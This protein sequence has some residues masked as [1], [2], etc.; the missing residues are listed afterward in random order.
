MNSTKGKRKKYF[1]WVGGGKY[2]ESSLAL[3]PAEIEELLSLDE[4]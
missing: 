3:F 4:N 2:S 1:F